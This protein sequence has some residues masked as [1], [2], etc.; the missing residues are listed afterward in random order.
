MCGMTLY[1]TSDNIS[2]LPGFVMEMRRK[3]E[4]QKCKS[5]LQSVRKKSHCIVLPLEQVGLGF[6]CDILRNTCIFVS[7]T[8]MF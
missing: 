5:S 8:V 2:V 3:C 6:R 7:G 1:K 4:K